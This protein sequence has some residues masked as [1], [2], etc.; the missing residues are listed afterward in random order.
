MLGNCCYVL[1][2]HLLLKNGRKPVWK[3]P[4]ALGLAS[5]CKAAVLYLLVVKIICGAASGLLL[6]KTLGKIVILAPPMLELLPAMFSLP[7]LLTALM[8]GT[9]ALI[10]TPVLEK[11]LHK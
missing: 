1:V 4:V 10:I 3:L 6:G 8:G 11:A 9:A 7:Q 2:L 5:V